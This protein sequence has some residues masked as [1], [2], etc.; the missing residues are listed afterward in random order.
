MK[1]IQKAGAPCKVGDAAKNLMRSNVPG[2][3]VAKIR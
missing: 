1:Y 2:S 3:S